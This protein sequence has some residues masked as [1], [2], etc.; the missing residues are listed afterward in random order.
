MDGIAQLTFVALDGEPPADLGL[1]ALPLPDSMLE[2][3]G[4]VFAPYLRADAVVSAWPGAGPLPG[5]DSGLHLVYVYGHAWIASDGPRLAWRNGSENQ[6]APGSEL[7]RLLVA[8]ERAKNTVL[9]LDCCHAAAFDASVATSEPPRLC[10]YACG[11]EEAA[12]ALHR[13]EATRLALALGRELRGAR[14]SVDLIQVVTRVADRLR[15]DDV[16]VG[17]SVSYRA[18]GPAVRLSQVGPAPA[19]RR[20]STVARIR[21]RLLV[22]GAAAAVLI[23]A[24]LWF[25]SG[26]AVLEVDVRALSEFAGSMRVVVYQEDPA[27]N[28]RREVTSHTFGTAPRVRLWVPASNIVVELQASYPDGA[29]RALNTHWVLAPGFDW[30]SKRVFPALPSADEVRRHPGMAYVPP[31]PWI[32]GKE[33]QARRLEQPYWIDLRPPT[34]AQY[35]ADARELLRTGR[36]APEH[37]FLLSWR[38]RSSAIDAVGLQAIRPLAKSLAD[39]ISVV[40]AAHADFLVEPGDIVTGAGQ[41][42]CDTCPAPMTRHEARVYCASRGYRLPTDLEWELA[43]RGV[44]G[45][46]YPWGERFDP[47]KANVPGL[48]EKGDPLQGLKPV[49]AYASSRSPFGL[50]DTVGNAGD[51][52][53]N[54]SGSYERVY[55]GAT[56]R[57]SPDDATAF[58]VLP[59]T[60]TYAYLVRE[61]TARCVSSSAVPPSPEPAS[62]R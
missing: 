58:R 26:Y 3:V 21:G 61:I 22:T 59:L 1:E 51:W 50:V 18:H 52:V 46:T 44:D 30:S 15:R 37:S 43:V 10:I 45:R 62:T 40:A 9:I 31:T 33:R 12:I 23:G 41:L 7:V 55:M 24:G 27:R 39:I 28:E 60:E 56:Y 49:D 38:Q 16:I 36:L 34:V 57:F 11:A 8:P 13:E 20:E 42:P 25:Y 54:E 2:F 4:N 47:G 14:E 17:Q 6:L 35:E 19:Q 32:H 5:P 48:P 29:A 53:L